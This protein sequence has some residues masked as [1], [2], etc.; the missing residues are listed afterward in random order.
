MA[1]MDLLYRLAKM[2]N[3]VVVVEEEEEEPLLQYVHF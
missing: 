2:V 3:V 1:L